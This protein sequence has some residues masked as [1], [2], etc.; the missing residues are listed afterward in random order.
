MPVSPRWGVFTKFLVS[1]VLVVLAGAVL[2]RFQQMI[3]PLVLSVILAYLLRPVVIALTERMRLAWSAAAAIVY[4]ALLVV[5]VTLLTVTGIAVVQ[6]VQGLY[7]VVVGIADNPAAQLQQILSQPIRLGPFL[8]DL[9]RPFMI[10]PFGPFQ[11]PLSGDWQPLLNQIFNAI[12]PALSRTGVLI[13]SLATGT[14]ETFGWTLFIL[15]ASYYLLSDLRSIGVSIERLVPADYEYDARRLVNELGPIWNAFL[16]GQMTLGIVM[17]IVV[18]VT[19]GVLGVRYAVVLGLLAGLLEFVPILGPLIAGTV[20]VLVALFQ[21][22]NWMGLNPPTFALVV[23]IASVVLQQIENNFLVPRILGGSLNLHP[24]VILVGALIAANLA[25]VI[26]LLLS[27]PVLATLRLFGQYIYRKMF[28]L[29]PW[30]EPPSITRA[31]PERKWSRWLR[32]RLSPLWTPLRP[33]PARRGPPQ[34][35]FS[36]IIFWTEQAR[37]WS[38]ERRA[39][40]QTAL[41]EVL[42]QPGFEN[43]AYQRRYNVPGLDEQAHAGSSLLALRK[44]LA[45]FEAGEAPAPSEEQAG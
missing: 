26:G 15:V 9:S 7:N 20:A 42:A 4:L 34:V 17:G 1:L 11:S 23:L 22:S 25:G 27:A 19:M 28:D 40:V 36:Y 43:N 18:G 37:Q 10:G 16:R 2:V 30:P 29:D 5:I 33:P 24:V 45:A 38:P 12:Q 44:V 3:A 32:R 6:Q 41:G 21:P 13:S 8:I 35:E 14:V 39:A 31:P